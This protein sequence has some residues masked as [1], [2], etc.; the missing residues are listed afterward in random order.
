MTKARNGY[1]GPGVGCRLPTLGR[2]FRLGSSEYV[3]ATA[4]PQLIPVSRKAVGDRR[5]DDEARNGYYGWVLDVDSQHSTAFLS[6]DEST[7]ISPVM[8]FAILRHIHDMVSE[9]SLIL[10]ISNIVDE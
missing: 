6:Q 9:N 7:R 1:Y 10:E 5:I 4:M 8:N 2:G 3:P